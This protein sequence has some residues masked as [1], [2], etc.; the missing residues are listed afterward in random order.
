MSWRHRCVAGIAGTIAI[1]RAKL[2]R[3]ADVGQGKGTT[4]R[5]RAPRLAGN[6]GLGAKGAAATAFGKHRIETGNVAAGA[7]KAGPVRTNATGGIRLAGGPDVD[8]RTKVGDA[9]RPVGGHQHVLGLEIK[10]GNATGVKVGHASADLSGNTLGVGA[11]HR[12]LV[13]R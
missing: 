6:R 13:F 5:R 7:R 12:L 3:E 11:I 2:G 1:R 10:M 4:S 8:A 9:H